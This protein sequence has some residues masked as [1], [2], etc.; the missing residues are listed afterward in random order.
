MHAALVLLVLSVV[1]GFVCVMTHCLNWGCAWRTGL[2]VS[3]GVIMSLALSVAGLYFC[4][5]HKT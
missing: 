2:T 1:S 5:S 4:V 3:R